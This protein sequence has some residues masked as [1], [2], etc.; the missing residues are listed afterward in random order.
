MKIIT[1]EENV[2]KDTGLL[3]NQADYII[4]NTIRNINYELINMYWNLGRIIT[5]YKEDKN[6]KYYDGV[7][8]LFTIKL[9]SKY[10]TGFNKSNIYYQRKRITRYNQ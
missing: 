6:S 3:I 8:K 10:G 9:Y 1:K 2:E 7:V 5:E 4:E